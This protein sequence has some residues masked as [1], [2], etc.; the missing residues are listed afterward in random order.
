MGTFVWGAKSITVRDDAGNHLLQAT[1]SEPLPTAPS[2]WLETVATAGLPTIQWP[3]QD[4]SKPHI[5]NMLPVK[6]L[7][8]VSRKLDATAD[9]SLVATTQHLVFNG[10]APG[11]VLPSPGYEQL[12]M[13]L[14]VKLKINSQLFTGRN[15]QTVQLAHGDKVGFIKGTPGSLS[16]P[17]KYEC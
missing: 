1:F 14:V 6:P 12:Q 17:T 7:V 16:G 4:K 3:L 13:V 15:N 11:A 10:T 8:A 9:D 5:A 2:I